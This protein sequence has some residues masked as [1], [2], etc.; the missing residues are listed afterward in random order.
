[1]F[2]RLRM[3]IYMAIGAL[4]AVGLMSA[5]SPTTDS[6][7]GAFQS[8][9]P[10]PDA[11]VVRLVVAP[12]SVVAGQVVHFRID[13]SR[14]PTLTYGV[15]YSIQQCVSGVWQ[16]APFSP[17]VFTRQRIRQRPSRGRWRRVPI[18]T[19]AAAGQYRVRKSVNDGIRGR[20]LYD[21]FDVVAPTSARRAGVPRN[22]PA[23][24]PTA[25]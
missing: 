19:T 17:T 15:D 14:G 16:L 12:G 4:A 24:S 10:P 8:C 18:P 25:K 5:A 2:V 1:M 23:P 9:A 7:S 20:W 13:N 3:L 6:A 11:G 21:D 22:P